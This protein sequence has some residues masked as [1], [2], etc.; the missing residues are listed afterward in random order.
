[1]NFLID[2]TEKKR[3]IV[4]KFKNNIFRFTEEELF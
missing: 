4:E 1:M 3:N 2:V